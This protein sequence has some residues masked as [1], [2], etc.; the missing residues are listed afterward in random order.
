MSYIAWL[1]SGKLRRDQVG[2]KGA[3]LSELSAAGFRVPLGFC[4]TADGYR[5]YA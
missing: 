2:G 5:Q 4:V 3:A 1:D